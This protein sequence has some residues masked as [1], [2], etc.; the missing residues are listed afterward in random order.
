MPCNS[1]INGFVKGGGIFSKM[2]LFGYVD[3][4]DD[5]PWGFIV[6]REKNDYCA[7]FEKFQ[8]QTRAVTV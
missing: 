4:D 5:F 2:P 7:F 8:S 1:R 6:A 3:D